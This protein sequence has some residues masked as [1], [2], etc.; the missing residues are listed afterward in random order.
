MASFRSISSRV[1]GVVTGVS[2]QTDKV[3]RRYLE[4]RYLDGIP[5]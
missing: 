4:K 5:L 1:V 2:K 3:S